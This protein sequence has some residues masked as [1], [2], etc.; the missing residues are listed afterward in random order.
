ME[1]FVLLFHRIKNISFRLSQDKQALLYV[2]DMPNN[3][4][5]IRYSQE[6]DPYNNQIIECLIQNNQWSFY[7]LRRDRKYPNKRGIFSY[8]NYFSIEF[9][10]FFSNSGG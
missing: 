3:F 9:F 6:L 2:Q 8:I 10:S 7:R 5:S 4:A 1:K